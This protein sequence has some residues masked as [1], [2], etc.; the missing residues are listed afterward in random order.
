[1][2]TSP[3]TISGIPPVPIKSKLV[4]A[5]VGDSLMWGQGLELEQK[6][7]YLAAKRLAE[8]AKKTFSPPDIR[9]RSGAQIA[10]SADP[11]TARG[12]RRA[13]TQV[14]PELFDGVKG[15]KIFVAG[16]DR[17]ADELEH[18]IP[19]P[20]PL[21]PTQLEMLGEGPRPDIDLLFLNGGANDV[22]F[23]KVLDP[24]GPDLL[25][26]HSALRHRVY[27]PLRDLLVK[28]RQKCPNALI[29]V[30]SYFPM[31]SMTGTDR[32]TVT[33]FIDWMNGMRAKYLPIGVAVSAAASTVTTL[34]TLPAGILLT[35]HLIENGIVIDLFKT[36]KDGL[37][38]I[39][40]KM[41]WRAEITFHLDGACRGRGA[42]DER[43][44][45]TGHSLRQPSIR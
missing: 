18:E 17:A 45:G 14:F 21:I 1:M 43:R 3:K 11:Q 15:T 30:P 8:R 33:D 41:R 9:A 7:C 2:S 5:A 23:V 40:E 4:C 36:N 38:D 6:F 32:G 37:N 42:A 25:N 28:T 34:F 27:Y 22:D 10:I 24:N 44:P 31:M 16:D 13:F 19:A 29:V 12:L 39:A 35:N 26:I 20:F